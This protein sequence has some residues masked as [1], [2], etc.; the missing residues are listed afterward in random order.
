MFWETIR[1][2]FSDVPD[3]V[4]AIRL[5]VRLLVA[6]FL[7]GALG[8]QRAETGKA[9]GT[10]THML[11]A[12]GAAMFVFVPQRLGA[13]TDDISRTLQGIIAGIGFIGA[14][15]IL[16][17][18]QE[19]KVRGLTTAACIW[20]TAAVGIAAGLGQLVTA[21][22]ITLL[23]FAIL[24]L[25]PRLGSFDSDKRRQRMHR[26]WPNESGTEAHPNGP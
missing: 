5:T 18:S 25:L 21:A 12:L 1:Q 23:A 3:G 26:L 20:L 17:L 15:T 16:K 10:R 7:G 22:A 2:E 19:E 14:G 9:A 8:W 13:D 6:T 11:V 24:S 4:A